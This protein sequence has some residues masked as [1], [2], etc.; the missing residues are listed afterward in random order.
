MILVLNCGSQSIKWK[1]FNEKFS[2]VDSGKCSVTNQNDFVVLLKNELN[3]IDSTKIGLIGHRVVYGG[4]TFLKPTEITQQN[5]EG[6]EKLNHLAPLHNPY[7]VLGIKTCQEIFAK[8][9]NIA[10]FDSGFYANLPEHASTYA[11]PEQIVQE[12]GFKRHGFHGTSHE[13]AA[14]MASKALK[15]PIN[16]LKI[17]T[18][19]LGGGS[20]ITAIKGGKAVDTSMGFTPAEGLV[21]MTR[22]GNIDSGIVLELVKNFSIEKAQE[23]LN[24]ESGIKGICGE[25]DMLKVFEKLNQKDA[26]AKLA[27]DIFVYNIQKYIGAYFAVLGGCDTLVFTGT[28]GSGTPDNRKVAKKI[29]EMVC[30]NLNILKKTEILAVDADEELAIAQKIYAK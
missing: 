29:R 6:L 27:L 18:C 17:I 23:I 3:K 15:R 4:S 5:I 28:I 8:I 2:V 9:P 1:L 30:R 26:K 24:K 11:L 12:F 13:Y 21:M 22:T 16:K 7:N 14:K 19:H 10:V 25:G 20:S